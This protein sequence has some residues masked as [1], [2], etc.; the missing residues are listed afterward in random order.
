[1]T[2]Q[3][4]HLQ[5]FR[6]ITIGK[7]NSCDLSDN[8]M[9]QRHGAYVVQ[10]SAH[11]CYPA[12]LYISPSPSG[13]LDRQANPGTPQTLVQSS[14]CCTCLPLSSA[15]PGSTSHPPFSENSALGDK[16]KI[17]KSLKRTLDMSFHSLDSNTTS[18]FVFL[19]S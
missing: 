12:E 15:R 10:L 11:S 7:N 18:S 8:I 5:V 9:Q 1:M 17:H 16:K 13:A 2:L 4:N 6:Q 14:H 3:D 19:S